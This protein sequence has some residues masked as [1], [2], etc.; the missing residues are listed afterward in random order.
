M[1]I[2]DVA[3][4][5]ACLKTGYCTDKQSFTRLGTYGPASIEM[6]QSVGLVSGTIH[7]DPQ[8]R[9]TIRKSK[10]FQNGQNT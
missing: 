1:R 3:V 10:K 5:M 8:V 4:A 9:L 2:V 7:M 6:A